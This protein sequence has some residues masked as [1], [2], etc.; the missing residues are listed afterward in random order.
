M[1]YIASSST[2]TAT[3]YLTELGRQYL[4]GNAAK[5]RFTTDLNGNKIDRFE[6]QK[7]SLG[8]ADTNYKTPM[9]L[10]AGTVPDVSGAAD[11]VIKG[12]KGRDL[13]NLITPGDATFETEITKLE[14]KTSIPSI[15]IDFSKNLS[16]IPTVYTVQ[17][18]TFINGQNIQ[19]GMYTVTPTNYGPTQ[20][21]QG[22]LTI[23][24]RD[25]TPTQVGYRMRIFFPTSGS[26]YNKMTIQFES[27]QYTSGSITET[28]SK[29]FNS[30]QIFFIGGLNLENV[31]VE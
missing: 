29:T 10:S 22:E 7:F 4:F 17:L 27:G 30:N 15:D 9:L 25:A 13:K 23:V 24:L 14:Y 31:V 11:D 18:M 28:H 12:A 5:T 1:G 19:D 16:T 20:A 26:D 2:V 3:A 21:K 6:P 8:D